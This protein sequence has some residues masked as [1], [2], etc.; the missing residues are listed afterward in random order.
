MDKP[1]LSITGEELRTITLAEEVFSHKVS[2]GNIY[3]AL[4]NEMANVRSGTASTKSRGEVHGSGA[5]PWPQKG[6]GRARAGHRRSPIWVGGGVVF[7]PKPRDYGYKMPKKAK[8]AAMKSVLSLKIEEERVKIIEDF[9][10]ETGKTKEL[11]KILGNLVPRERTVMILKD[12]DPMIKRAGANIPWLSFLSYNRLRVHDLFYGKHILLLETA[13][14]KLNEFY[15]KKSAK[16]NGNE[17]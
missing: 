7:G 8:R 10:V 3:Y 9:T 13:A 15:S 6:T 12:D 14:Q 1:V 5:K 4:R 17:S 2:E 16:G 11:V